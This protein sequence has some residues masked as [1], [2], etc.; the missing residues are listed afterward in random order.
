MGALIRAYDLGAWPARSP[1]NMAA[2][3]ADNR[4]THPEIAC[5][6]VTLWGAKA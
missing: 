3:P 2:K 4:R 1:D 6:I 5:R